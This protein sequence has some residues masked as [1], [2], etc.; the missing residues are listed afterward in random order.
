MTFKH[1]PER[2]RPITTRESA[3][4]LRGPTQDLFHFGFGDPVPLNV[5][6]AR[7]TVIIIAY[8]HARRSELV[9][10]ALSLGPQYTGIVAFRAP[11]H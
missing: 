6:E 8:L 11:V 9:T 10:H 1:R 2:V 4:I 7:G 3:A 5:R